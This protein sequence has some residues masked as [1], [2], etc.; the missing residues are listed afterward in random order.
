MR[1]DQPSTTAYKVAL[2]ILTL[3]A[4]PGMDKVLPS[5]I[6]EA[7]E[8]LLLA[9]G[10]IPYSWVR[11]A[12]TQSMT[13][14]YKSLDWMLPGMYLG[15]AYRKAFFERQVRA[16]I[17]SGVTQVLVLGAGYDTLGWRLAPEFSSVHFYEIDHPAT[18]CFKAKGIEAMGQRENLHLIQADLG[19]LKLIDVLN[20][21]D[22]WNP[23]EK[24]V[25][26]AEGLLMYLPKDAVR[27]LFVQCNT[28]TGTG[29]RIAFDYVSSRADGRPDVGLWTESF[30]WLIKVSGEPWHWSIHPED[31]SNFLEST[32]WTNTP[33][34]VGLSDKCGV[35]FLCVA[36]K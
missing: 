12:R 27:D 3:G 14:L 15:L 20:T 26:L 30:L 24:T 22:S 25:I 36:A 5:G 8:K 1:K 16:A 2:N 7:T 11:W 19:K 6:V 23:A 31:L 21:I 28:I 32:G 35:E 34:L 18:A 13:Y 10:A 33:E 4:E 9:S 17:E 29:S